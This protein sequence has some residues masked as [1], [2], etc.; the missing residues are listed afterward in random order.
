MME[1]VGQGW[2][3]DGTILVFELVEIHDGT[4]RTGTDPLWNQTQAPCQPV[5]GPTP[6]PGIVS[7]E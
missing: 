3:H 4:S 2:I 6:S 7:H 5:V 1:P